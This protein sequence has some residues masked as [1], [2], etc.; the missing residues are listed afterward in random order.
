MTRARQDGLYFLLIGSLTFLLMGGAMENANR[1]PLSDFK[2]I[3][4]PARC[5]LQHGDP[6]KVSDVL[7]VYRADGENHP[8]DAVDVRQ[9]ATQNPY[10]PTVFAVSLF[11][12]MLPWGPAHI[13]W[14]ALCAGSFL[15]ASFLIWNLGAKDAPTLSGALIG[16]LLANSELLLMTG[17]AAG[18]AISLCVV[19]VWCF[20]QERYIPAGIL[21]LALSLAIKPHD[22]GLVWLYFLLAG[23]AY[24]KRAWQTLLAVAALTLPAV[25]WVWHLSPHWIQE[26]R[27]NILAFS[28]HGGM[29]DPFLAS[30]GGR[31]LDMLVN[32]QTVTSAFRNEP[33]FYNLVSYLICAP[34]LLAWAFVTLR[35][36]PSPKRAWLALAAI[37]ALTMLPVYHRQLDAK[38]LLLT[39]PA[40]AMLWAE[41]GRIG[42]LAFLVN[43]A[44]FVLIGDFSWTLV[45]GITN[46]LNLHPAGFSGQ[47]VKGV[48]AFSSPLIL[49]LMGVFYLWVYVSRC[50]RLAAS[51]DLGS[52]GKSP[53][54]PGRLDGG[55][56]LKKLLG[57]VIPGAHTIFGEKGERA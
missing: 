23:G 11:F 28:A 50:S 10:P 27:A 37:A 20:L 16:F 22:A 24:R 53:L 52:H 43:L 17:N 2:G 6:Y 18:I 21:C 8:S 31:G 55:A 45:M 36:R 39:V 35:F 15:F 13:L 54:A 4:Y 33:R 1:T 56:G 9:I 40:C 34:L 51:A 25:L 44:G 12:A 7:R 48:E 19:A 46:G 29:N 57:N 30:A 49:L 42:R 47:M 3:Y 32:L 14:L 41:G 38:L 5:L 26:M